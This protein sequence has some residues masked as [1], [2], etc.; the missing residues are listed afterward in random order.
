MHLRSHGSGGGGCGD[1]LCS[2]RLRGAQ[3]QLGCLE[4]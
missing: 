3:L 2:R 4:L 1:G